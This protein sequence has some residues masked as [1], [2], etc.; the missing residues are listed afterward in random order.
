MS[1]SNPNDTGRIRDP[2]G[3]IILKAIAI[4]KT[5]RQAGWSGFLLQRTNRDRISGK[6]DNI[7]L[8]R[9][10][11][12][13]LNLSSTHARP[14]TTNAL[15]SVENTWNN[16]NNLITSGNKNWIYAL[17][18]VVRHSLYDQRKFGIF[19]RISASKF[20]DDDLRIGP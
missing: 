15:I 6:F 9:F 4:W 13:M 18:N 12:S 7:F 20:P 19:F 3:C 11:Q 10:T 1:W 17:E 2:H 14:G 16:N 5:Q 8:K